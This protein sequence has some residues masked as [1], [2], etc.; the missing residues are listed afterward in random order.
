VGFPKKPMPKVMLGICRRRNGS[1]EGKVMSSSLNVMNQS[2]AR[3]KWNEIQWRKL[4]I[5]NFK[6]QKR[7][8]RAS[9]RGDVK[10]VRKLQKLLLKSRAAKL[11]AVRRVTQDNQGKKTPG[12]DGVAK[13]NTTERLRLAETLKLG[14]KCKPVR[15]VWI[16]KPG[17][18]EK[19]GLGIPTMATRAE[20]TLTKM[21][22][23]PEWEAKFGPNS[24]GFR[25][26]RSC[27]DARE[28]IFQALSKKTAFV[29]DADISGCFDNIDHAALLAKLNTTP[30][31]RKAIKG[32]LK[33]GVMEGTIFQST[34]LGTPQGGAISPLLANIALHGLEY[35]TKQALTKDLFQY[36]KKTYGRADNVS[37]KSSISIIVYADDF[38]VIHEDRNIVIKAK[39]F[40]E[41]WLR[42]IGLELSTK[43][44]SVVHTLN[45]IDNQKPGFNFLGFTIRQF[46]DKQ[47]KKGCKTLIK[48]SR[49]SQKQHAKEIRDILKRMRPS[50]QAEVIRKLNPMIRGWSR[51]F[52]P[53]VS[54]DVFGR[55]DSDMF[56]KL[57]SWTCRRHPNKGKGWVRRKYFRQH[58]RDMW[59]FKTHDGLYLAKHQDHH[60]KRHVKVAGT[61]TPYNGDWVYWGTRMGKSPGI[62]PRRVKLLK[63]QQGKCNH[64][65]LWFTCNDK[66]EV[67]HRDKNHK[68]NN[69]NNL[70]LVHKHCHDNIHKKKCA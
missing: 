43:K 38:V 29:L 69:M 12:I 13:L 16:P 39:I 64:C 28:A 27:H 67:H 33:A 19:R 30:S 37:A 34:E 20:Q 50:T 48:P 63:T 45:P 31:I 54:C 32:W 55:L 22:L 57:W 18:A 60:I 5:S 23:E 11:L 47:S 56:Y 7:I 2:K 9:L 1:I 3:Y 25:P 26:G 8:Y 36:R 53:A 52:V 24:Y 15:R 49:E 21:A 66:M 65:Q 14:E 35:D 46:Q 10:L 42:K 6:L 61:R 59:R 40:I 51:Y 41:E 4:E 68:N 58:D 62:Q 44:T 17:K 70:A